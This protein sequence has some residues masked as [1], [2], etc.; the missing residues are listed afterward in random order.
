MTCRQ[1]VHQ[2]IS[3]KLLTF[4]MKE[5]GNFPPFSSLQWGQHAWGHFLDSEMTK[6]QIEN[7]EQE[8]KRA[9]DELIASFTNPGLPIF[10]LFVLWGQ[11]IELYILTL[12]TQAFCYSEPKIFLI[13]KLWDQDSNSENLTPGAMSLIIPF[14]PIVFSLLLSLLCPQ[15]LLNPLKP[16][17]FFLSPNLCSSFC[18]EESSTY[19]LDLSLNISSSGKSFL[20][21]LHLPDKVS[22]LYSTYRNYKQM[23]IECLSPMLHSKLVRLRTVFLIVHSRQYWLNE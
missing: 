7:A 22:S 1:K 9:C 2:R 14:L 19:P 18:L 16:P 17:C 8:M 5:P 11:Y 15:R 4:L 12:M 13:D 23:S 6:Q 21:F 3:E 20:I 10:S